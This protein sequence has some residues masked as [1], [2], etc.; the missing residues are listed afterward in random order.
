MTTVPVNPRVLVWARAER[1]LDT[2]TAAERLGITPEE[3][4][5]LEDGEVIPNVT[6]LRSMANKYGISFSALLM[7]EPLPPATRLRVE[8]FRTRE[9]GA[10]IWT[11]ELLVM[12]DEVNVLIDGLADL[13][14]GAPAAFQPVELPRATMISDPE[15]VAA[16]ERARMG[17]GIETQLG[18]NTPAEAFRRFRGLVEESGVFVYLI[19]AGD[20]DDWRGL[21]VYDDRQIPLIII[22][23]DE[24][25]PAWRLFTLMHEYYHLLLRQTGVS[26]QRSNHSV[27]ALCNQFAAHFLMPADRFI[28]EARYV[29]SGH[30]PWEVRDAKELA[31]R[32]HVSITAAAIHLEDLGL[33][34]K[35]YGDQVIATLHRPTRRKST[36]GPSYYEKMA[37]RY[38]C[39]HFDVVFRALDAGALDRVEAY[40]LTTVQP[41]YFPRMRAEVAERRAAYG[42]RT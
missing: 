31:V 41:E 7:P 20:T 29:N 10:P 12:L 16:S 32:F 13:Q 9:S 19:N 5:A 25:Q 14:E 22:N 11:P 42:W 2:V 4:V 35:G 36:G 8:D 30:R 37:N 3:L 17:L 28:A 15:Q 33:A 39:R 6:Q 21:A 40:E 1:G 38:G 24:G 23:G 34:P 26:D 18:L 27:E